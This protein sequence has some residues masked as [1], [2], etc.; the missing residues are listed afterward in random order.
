[1]WPSPNL[2]LKLALWIYLA[3]AA[4]ALLWQRAERRANA[5]GFGAAALAGLSGL[6]GGWSFLAGGVGAAS[7]GFE[8][9]PLC[10]RTCV[11]PSGWM[12]SGR[13]SCCWYRCWH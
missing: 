4:G 13:S 9:L 12:H 5:I 10:S 3:G 11:C 8:L 7:Q 2:L 1:M 6:L